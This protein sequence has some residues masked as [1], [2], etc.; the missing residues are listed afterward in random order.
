MHTRHSPCDWND[1]FRRRMVFESDDESVAYTDFVPNPEFV[2]P[3]VPAKAG[4]GKSGRFYWAAA[5]L[6]A[7][8]AAASII[9]IVSLP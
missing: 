6:A 5:A 1:E 3:A 7:V 8:M 2:A 9:V 4:G